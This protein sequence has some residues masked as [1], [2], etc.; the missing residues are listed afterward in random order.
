M[1]VFYLIVA[2]VLGGDVGWG[3]WADRRLRTANAPAWLRWIVRLFAGAQAAYLAFFLV[4]PRSARRVHPWLPTSFIASAY[5]W[6]LL[7]LPV[8]LIL[9]AVRTNWRRSPVPQPPIDPHLARFSRRD[10]LRVAAVALPPV[11]TVLATARSMPQLD[12]FR[13]NRLTLNL[14]GLPPT[15]DGL[16][17]VHLSDLHVGKFT[18]P[19]LLPNIV[20]A[21]NRLP[22]DL[23][24]FTGDLIDLSIDDLDRGVD[25]L[26][27]LDP[28]AGFAMVEGNHDLIEDP[29][30]FDRRVLAARLPLLLNGSKTVS[31]R[32]ERVQ[33]LGIRWGRSTGNRRQT[34][35]AA[36][37]ESVAT[38]Q[39]QRDPG[40]FPIL[41]GHHPH[42]FDAAA[43]AG[44]PLVLS[45]HTHG[46]QLMAT[47]RVGFGPL[48]FRYWS[49]V[50]QKPSSH[51][52]VNN[53][54]GNWF[55][56][57]V[58]APAEIIHLTLRCKT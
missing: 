1:V 50:Y 14:P 13:I 15:L 37:A 28:R 52:V 34:D 54:I 35:E 39:A 26:K 51:L 22:A 36:F 32:G 57:R 3:W 24:V 27:Q 40:A 43:Q 56:L 25:T 8:A 4:A 19:G 44:F 41:L 45:G 46:G 12:A 53:G 17:I 48:F 49:G 9:L 38:V 16:R 11:V 6:H 29:D 10:A 58:N 31:L 7:V 18:R 20:E 55:P 42:C 5:L 47:R 30:A 33:L 2:A 23:L 21:T